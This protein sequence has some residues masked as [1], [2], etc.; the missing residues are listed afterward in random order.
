MSPV[1]SPARAWP[2]SPDG[3]TGWAA[4]HRHEPHPSRSSVRVADLVRGDQRR[5]R[6]ASNASAASAARTIVDGSGILATRNPMPFRSSGMR[7]PRNEESRG[8]A[9]LLNAPPRRP[10]RRPGKKSALRS[11][12]NVAA[13]VIGTVGAG[14][15][16]VRAYVGQIAQDIVVV[17]R[18][19]RRSG[20]AAV[21]AALLHVGYG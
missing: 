9:G 14:C 8:S 20:T 6:H 3:R 12:E 7:R 2:M 17:R 19:G 5:R 15:S 21:G 10:D 11:I 18:I 16:A 4:G 1:P 13:H